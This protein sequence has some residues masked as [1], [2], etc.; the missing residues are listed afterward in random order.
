MNFPVKCTATGVGD[1][2]KDS[3]PFSLNAACGWSKTYKLS[4]YIL[5][6]TVKEMDNIFNT[7][8]DAPRHITVLLTFD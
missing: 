5:Q 6:Q 8:T 4:R 7:D 3:M 1:G 2:A